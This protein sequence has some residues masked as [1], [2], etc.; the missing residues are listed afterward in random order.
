MSEIELVTLV[1]HCEKDV[2][3]GLALIKL[4]EALQIL[5][6]STAPSDIGAHVDLAINRLRDE[7][8]HPI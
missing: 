5:D 4:Q 1:S 6:D 2:S 8:S 7:V 3:L